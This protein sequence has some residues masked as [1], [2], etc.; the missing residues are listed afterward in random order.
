[1]AR[2][3]HFDQHRLDH[4]HVRGDGHAV[5]QEPGVLHLALVVVDVFLV[6]RPTDALRRAALD[7]AFDVA[8]V[9]RLADI[10]D[11]GVALDRD[12]TG[13]LIDRHVADVRAEAGA[14]ALRVHRH[15]GVD[16]AAGAGRL[17]RQR[18]QIQRLE[19][20]GVGTGRK[21]LAVLP[22]DRFDRDLPGRGGAPLELID[23][24]F[25]RLRR[26]HAG[27]EGHAGAAG[28][29]GE[30][31]RGGVGDHR[32]DPFGRHAEH[33][34]HHHADGRARAADIRAAG[35]GGDRAVLVDVHLG[36]RFAADVE[37][38]AGGQTAALAFLQRRLPVRV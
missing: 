22:L 21:R 33:L 4:R 13:L 15:L 1:M 14:G 19:R 18:G 27:G 2:V 6:Q 35:R 37:P 9:D 11:R 3:G 38:E 20:T 34:G 24:L 29:E 30:A 26:R 5:I 10:L 36:G 32:A 8:G 12:V 25:G 7:L 16:R 31:D 28:Q 23:D 17:Q